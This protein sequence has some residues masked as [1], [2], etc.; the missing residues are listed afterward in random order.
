M[1]LLPFS[2]SNK[3]QQLAPLHLAAANG[4]LEVVK[5]LL[6]VNSEVCLVQDRNG[7]NPLHVAIIK[8]QVEVLQELVRAKPEAVLVRGQGGES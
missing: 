5:T 6:S 2:L 7:R 4:H 1:G 8:G 3:Y